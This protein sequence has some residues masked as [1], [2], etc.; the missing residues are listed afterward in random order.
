[1]SGQNRRT[2]DPV[3]RGLSMAVALGALAF[4]AATA[5][6]NSERMRQM[7]VDLERQ[8]DDLSKRMESTLE[9]RRPEIEDA[10]ERSRRVA[11]QGLE[12]VKSAVEEGADMAQTYVQRTTSQAS[13]GQAASQQAAASGGGETV[14]ET[15]EA[16]STEPGAPEFSGP[17]ETGEPTRRVDG[18]GGNDSDISRNPGY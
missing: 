11:M 16:A 17:S 10:I 14:E 4:G 18:D 2:D 6:L 5:F 7:R 1:M 8:I 15:V 3:A 13:A 12:K 9:E